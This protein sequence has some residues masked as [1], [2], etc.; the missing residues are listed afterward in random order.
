MKF[1][2]LSLKDR[3]RMYVVLNYHFMGFEI[4]N[5]TK[6]CETGKVSKDY[7]DGYLKGIDDFKNRLMEADIQTLRSNEE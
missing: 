4:A 6:K 2:E 7:L 5:L 3:F 1:K